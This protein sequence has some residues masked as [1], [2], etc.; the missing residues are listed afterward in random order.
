[1]VIQ[2]DQEREFKGAVK[3]VSRDMKIKNNLHSPLLPT[4]SRKS[5][6]LENV[7]FLRMSKKGVNW[8]KELPIYQRVLNEEPKEVLKYKSAF[9]VYYARKPASSKTDVM[10]DDLLTNAGKGHSEAAL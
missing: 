3:N 1:M 9:Q 6:L 8:M 4:I 10:N 2:S 7:D 5:G